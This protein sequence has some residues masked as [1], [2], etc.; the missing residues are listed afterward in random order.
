MCRAVKKLAVAVL[1]RYGA[2]RVCPK[3]LRVRPKW[4]SVGSWHKWDWLSLGVWLR[5]VMRVAGGSL[6]SRHWWN[7]WRSERW[8]DQLLRVVCRWPDSCSTI[9]YR[10]TLRLTPSHSA[11]KQWRCVAF[12]DSLVVRVI[13][14]RVRVIFTAWQ[15]MTSCRQILN[16]T[17]RWNVEVTVASWTNFSYPTEVDFANDQTLS[18]FL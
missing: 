14:S 11:D 12:F 1:N 18:V 5:D 7:W 16:E 6:S 15:I 13:S 9:A 10:Y 2:W 4:H 3:I 8:L 17:Y